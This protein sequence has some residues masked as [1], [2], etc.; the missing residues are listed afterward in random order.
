MGSLHHPSNNTPEGP[1]L[2]KGLQ[3]FLWGMMHA[4]GDRCL[5]VTAKG[6]IDV[7]CSE[8]LVGDVLSVLFWGKWAF[9]AEEESDVIA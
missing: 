2:F 1:G 7:W 4:A 5:V 9:C 6:Y 3:R 8:V